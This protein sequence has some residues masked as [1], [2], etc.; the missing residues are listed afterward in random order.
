MHPK[1]G[2]H[3]LYSKYWVLHALDRVAMPFSKFWLSYKTPRLDRYI[4][5]LG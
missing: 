4:L 3:A 2:R 5:K 1:Q